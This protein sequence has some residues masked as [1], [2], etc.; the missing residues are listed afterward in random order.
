MQVHAH[1]HALTRNTMVGRGTRSCGRLGVAAPNAAP[2]AMSSRGRPR[3][4]APSLSQ[5][6][7]GDE[8]TQKAAMLL[9]RSVFY[10]G[11]VRAP[12]SPPPPPP[13]KIPSPTPRGRARAH[14]KKN[15]ALA[16]SPVIW[17][18]H[19]RVRAS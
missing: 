18:S 11:Q 3:A 19:A 10:E 7:H 2:N 9:R 4:R 15:L 5:V 1:K 16:H 12:T 6:R 13:P 14:L 8:D 17:L